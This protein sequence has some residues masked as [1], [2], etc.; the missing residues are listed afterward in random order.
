MS[1]GAYQPLGENQLD[2]K[3]VVGYSAL[4][5]DGNWNE[6][7]DTYSYLMAQE[8]SPGQANADKTPHLE[9][10][11][12]TSLGDRSS[13][14]EG[15]PKVA[16]WQSSWKP[17]HLKRRVI[18]AFIALI[19]AM[20]VALE[21]MNSLSVRRQGLVQSQSNLRYL[22]TYGPT[23]VLTIFAAFWRRVEYETHLT[24]PWLRMEKAGRTSDALLMDYIDMWS[25]TVPFRAMRKGD[26]RVAA[27]STIYLLL[28]IQT[29]IS[30]SLF[31]LSTVHISGSSVPVVINSQFIDDPAR[32]ADPS[33]LPFYGM[34]GLSTDN[35]S[36]PDGCS[37]QYTY[38]SFNS[39]SPDILDVTATVDGLS[40]ELD[41]DEAAS[42]LT[43]I[44]WG[45]IFQEKE[46]DQWYL[47]DSTMRT[48]YDGCHTNLTLDSSMLQ[49][50][51]DANKLNGTTQTKHIMWLGSIRGSGPGQCGS[52]DP[53]SNRLVLLSAKVDYMYFNVTNS[54]WS[55]VSGYDVHVKTLNLQST[56]LFCKPRL[57]LLSL[58]VTKNTTGV[59]SISKLSNETSRTLSE[60]HPWTIV[61]AQLSTLPDSVFMRAPPTVVGNTTVIGNSYFHIVTDACGSDCDDE[62]SLFNTTILQH[63]LTKHY[64]QYAAFLLHQSLKTPAD[65]AASGTATTV[66]NRL[67]VQ[68]LACHLMAAIFALSILILAGILITM[69]K[70]I[71]FPMKPGSVI[72]YAVI[73]VLASLGYVPAQLGGAS[74]E[75]L[76]R[77][78]HS[79]VNEPEK[80]AQ[81]PLGHQLYGQPKLVSP[82][83]LCNW[84]RATVYLFMMGCFATLE[85]TLQR[86]SRDNGL[87]SV[88]DETYL[89]YAW[90]AFPA[91]VLSLL[92][93]FMSSVDFRNRLLMPYQ[94]LSRGAS[95]EYLRLDLLRPMLPRTLLKEFRFKSFAALIGT[96]AAL[97]GSRLTI[98]SASLFHADV[99]PVSN[100]ASLQS[101]STILMNTP[102]GQE[103]LISTSDIYTAALILSSNLS[104]T[105]FIYENLLLP[106]FDLDDHGTASTTATINSSSLVTRATVPA[107]RPGLTCSFYPT[108]SIS[109]G[110]F[111]GLKLYELTD[112]TYNG[113]SVNIT[114]Q[115]CSQTYGDGNWM[116][117]ANNTATF[118]ANLT[119]EF[120]FA[121][122]TFTDGMAVVPCSDD[123]LYIFGH[124][125]GPGASD[126]ISVSAL[127]CN[128]TAESIDVE[129]TYAGAD[130]KLDPSTPPKPIESTA[131]IIPGHYNITDGGGNIFEVL[132]GSLASLPTPN[133][134]V[135]DEFFSQLVTSRYAIPL[136]WIADPAKVEMVK[137]AIL[138]QHGIYAAQYIDLR[139]RVA[140]NASLSMF[141]SLSSATTDGDT[142]VCNATVTDPYGS[143]RIVQDEVGTRILQTLLLAALVLSVLSWLLGP[144]KPVLPRSP[145]SIASVLALL[146]G[147]DI[148]EHVNGQDAAM[149]WKNLEQLQ[150]TL[151]DDS[152]FW[153]GMGPPDEQLPDDEK[154]FGIWVLAGRK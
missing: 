100:S 15:L 49:F 143:P 91:V 59:Q 7:Y 73:S 117:Y 27:V 145:T 26:Y 84:S 78:I 98:G 85:A 75:D 142:G 146:S 103:G 28:I 23:T 31:T 50:G 119:S 105:P 16:A 81:K 30:T 97:I 121:S 53:D 135:F 20:V 44:D 95:F 33:Q 17:F 147:G 86:S 80:S 89:H 130:L 136:P 116:A 36:Y 47:D 109:T 63:Y 153:L 148:L 120:Y 106:S 144:K 29:I 2:Q 87:G 55:G 8:S 122:S 11:R 70:S 137:E 134:T 52:T 57:D 94:S 3:P 74:K 39:T 138:F 60:I 90:T 22:W 58:A 45:R 101:T 13:D 76:R 64:Q 54:T 96:I 24:A 1:P 35:M 107:L 150:A 124:Y 19:A 83:A 71:I 62:S 132:Y 108:S 43:E 37:D 38:Q 66:T 79:W 149:E 127:G 34:T 9:N 41:C 140:L 56:S 113:I 104:Y 10:V 128:R 123:V 68:P 4:P 131:K 67:M 40:L 114:G 118:A 125:P 82:T 111:Y 141:P 115:Q 92:G 88:P 65:A 129:V 154:R 126:P 21:V 32:L 25:P 61:Q 18:F 12:E 102:Y 42:T 14:H 112:T 6:P 5:N 139:H 99:F 152:Q 93:L 133:D 69:P 151:G 46:Y 77:E 110:Q 72:S 51:S 48:S